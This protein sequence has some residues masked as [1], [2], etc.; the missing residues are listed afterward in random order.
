MFLSHFMFQIDLLIL[1]LTTIEGIDLLLNGLLSS[2][3][4]WGSGG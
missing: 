1:L 2:F 4:N 3:G